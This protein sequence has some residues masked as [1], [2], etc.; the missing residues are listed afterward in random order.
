MITKA[1]PLAVDSHFRVRLRRQEKIQVAEYTG[2]TPR[3]LR[4]F[5]NIDVAMSKGASRPSPCQ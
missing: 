1:D 3:S 5:L 2:V 4:G